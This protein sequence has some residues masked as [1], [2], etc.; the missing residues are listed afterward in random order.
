MMQYSLERIRRD[1]LLGC[2]GVVERLLSEK[3]LLVEALEA[4]LKSGIIDIDG[5]PEM[6]RRALERVWEL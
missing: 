2:L 6:A 1:D 4:A 5:E 3:R